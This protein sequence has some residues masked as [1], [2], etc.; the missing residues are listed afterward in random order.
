M[1]RSLRRLLVDL[2]ICVTG[3]IDALEALALPDFDD[4]NIDKNAAIAG[5]LG[6]SYYLRLVLSTY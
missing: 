5:L 2:I 1:A 6:L 3:K 4:P